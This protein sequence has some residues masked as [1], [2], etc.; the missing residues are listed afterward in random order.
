VSDRHAIGHQDSQR[1]FISVT[2]GSR[3]LAFWDCGEQVCAYDCLCVF[4][5]P[6][7]AD[8]ESNNWQTRRGNWK[9]L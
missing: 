1:H 7:W 2:P 8:G 6:H 5:Q 3:A 9:H 4:V